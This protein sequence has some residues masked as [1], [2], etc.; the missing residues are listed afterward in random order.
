MVKD[1][2]FLRLAWSGRLSKVGVKKDKDKTPRHA[3]PRF[4]LP[5]QP[6][7]LPQL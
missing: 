2:G 4:A 7:P 3:S 5:V 1:L 6:P